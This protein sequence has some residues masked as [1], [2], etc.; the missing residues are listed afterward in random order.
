M[1]P[2][3]PSC[4][5]LW[6]YLL[7]LS[8]PSL[9]L[10]AGPSEPR[11]DPAHAPVESPP[12]LSLSEQEYLQ[13]FFLEEGAAVEQQQQP[14]VQEALPQAPVPAE[15]PEAIK[16]G[17][18][19]QMKELYPGDPWDPDNPLI[20]GWKRKKKS[21]ANDNSWITKY[22]WPPKSWREKGLLG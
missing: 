2:G 19:I 6:N 18:I 4:L 3:I 20:R 9:K 7:P 12:L 1:H 16:N 21:T 5:K 17:I 13:Q 15:D 22:S 14:E 11:G 8:I 10:G